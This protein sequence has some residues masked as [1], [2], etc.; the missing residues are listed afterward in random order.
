MIYQLFPKKHFKKVLGTSKK[1]KRT[2]Q[3]LETSGKKIDTKHKIAGTVGVGIIFFVSIILLCSFSTGS[4]GK[5]RLSKTLE[6]VGNCY[7]KV[8][9]DG[10]PIFKIVKDDGSPDNYLIGMDFFAQDVRKG[11]GWE[12]MCSYE[13]ME[14]NYFIEDGSL[15]EKIFEYP[16]IAKLNGKW[17]VFF[18]FVDLAAL[19]EKG[20]VDF[21]WGTMVNDKLVIKIQYKDLEKYLK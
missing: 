19:K 14:W 11:S 15:S 13:N 6:G 10:V 12:K 9:D 1:N 2:V 3:V 7:I 8:T 16:F 5:W 4:G 17:L 18:N 20:L 21:C